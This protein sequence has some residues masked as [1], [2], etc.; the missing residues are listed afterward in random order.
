[1]KDY[2]SDLLVRIKNGQRAK[3]PVVSMHPYLPNK[4]LKIL[5]LLY[6]EGYIRGYVMQYDE[7]N[8][9]IIYNVLLKY[10]SRGEPVIENLYRISKPGRRVYTSIKSLWQQK[11]GQGLIV[12]STPKGI[13]AD[14]D[15][16]LLNLG[17][18]ALFGIY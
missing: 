17:G 12:I 8:K 3:L 11:N 5:R 18:E 9:K 15:A 2:L 7:M 13:M 6:R 1:M 4:Y 14:R 16:R 10:S